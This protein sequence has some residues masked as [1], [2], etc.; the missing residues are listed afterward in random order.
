MEGELRRLRSGLG[1]EGGQR[2]PFLVRVR[3][4]AEDPTQV[5]AG[6]RAVLTCVVEQHLLGRP[7]WDVREYWSIRTTCVLPECRTGS[8]L[9]S[10]PTDTTAS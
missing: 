10:C 1:A 4:A 9:W 8:E 7:R 2:Q 5:I 6:A 3:F